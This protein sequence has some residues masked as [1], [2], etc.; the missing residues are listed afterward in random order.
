MKQLREHGIYCLA[1]TPY[2]YTARRIP[3]KPVYRTANIAW[4]LI[5]VHPDHALLGGPI[6]FVNNA[7]MLLRAEG[8]LAATVDSLDFTGRYKDA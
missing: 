1:L 3:D 2:Q 6:L 8:T 5:P 4:V 7:G